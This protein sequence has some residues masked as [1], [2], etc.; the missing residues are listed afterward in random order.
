MRIIG[1]TIPDNKQILYGLTALHGIGL[2]T[3]GKILKQ[4]GVDPVTK[5]KDVGAEKEKAIRAIIEDMTLEGELKRE[6]SMNIKRLKDIDSYRGGRHTRSLPVRGQRTKVNAR[7][8][9]G[10]KRTVGSGKII[11]KLK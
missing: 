3:S 5:T 8:R 7:T 10:K 4:V 6:V 11:T 1:I 9:K 2:S